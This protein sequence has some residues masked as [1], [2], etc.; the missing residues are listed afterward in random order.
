L[1]FYFAY[2]PWGLSQRIIMPHECMIFTKGNAMLLKEVG[3]SGQISLGKS[4]AGKLFNM[5]KLD[6]GELRL[7]PMRAVEDLNAPDA[8]PP[9][10][11]KA[12]PFRRPAQLQA[13]LSERDRWEQ[14]NAEA[15]EAFNSRV[16]EIG[17]PAKRLHAWRKAQ[18][19]PA[20]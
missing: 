5:Q 14:S 10:P 17:S 1:A 19:Q 16:A 11:S 18:S 9:S 13:L 4:F 3:A 7:L 8:E 20:I 15:I 12:P 6:S 2:L